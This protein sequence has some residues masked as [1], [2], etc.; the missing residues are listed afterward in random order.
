M[1]VERRRP[2]HVWEQLPGALGGR[3]RPSCPSCGDELLR[4]RDVDLPGV[5]RLRAVWVC[6][7]AVA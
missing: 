2:R 1:T 3:S 6:S 7:C 4:L 5:G